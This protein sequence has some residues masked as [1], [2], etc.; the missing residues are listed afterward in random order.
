LS[1]ISAGGF[2]SMSN[3]SVGIVIVSHSDQLALGVR[4][5]ALQMASGADVPVIPAGGTEDGRL[6]TSPDKLL[7][8][9]QQILGQGGSAL[10]LADLGSSIMVAEMVLD[11]L[12][13]EWRERVRLADA[14]LVEGAV[15]A[16]V[17]A[18]GGES[19]DAVQHAAQQVTH[20]SKIL[21]SSSHSAAPPTAPEEI[22]DV[23]EE[24]IELVIKNLSGL[25]AR[26][27]AR[28][29]QAAMQFQSHITVQ[30]ASQQRPPVN[31]KSIVEVASGGTAWRGE[32][33]RIVARGKDAQ[34]AIQTLK[35][36]VESGF[37]E[38]ESPEVAILQ[39]VDSSKEEGLR[40]V[41]ASAG[42][43]IAPVF[44]YR[45]ITC[46]IERYLVQDIAA[47]TAR[48]N[49]ALERA[50][51]ELVNLQQEVAVHH[52]ETAR[53]FEFQRLMLEDPT[54][55]RA[56]ED[57]IQ[58]AALNAEAAASDVFQEW[59]TRFE[60][61]GTEIARQR[62]ADVRDI[63]QRTIRALLGLSEETSLHTV[64]QPV[65]L[66][67]QELTPSDTAR[68][69]RELVTGICTVGGG[70]TSHVA[71][72][73]RMWNIPAV[74]GIEESALNIS[75]GTLVVLDGNTGQLIVNPA[76]EV[77]AT[78]QEK[79]T[80]RTVQIAEAIRQSQEMAITKDGRRIEVF[81][82]IGS[83]AS[84][85]EALSL[86][87]EGVGLLRTEFLFVDRATMPGEEEQYAA[88]R[89]IADVMGDRPL[90][91]RTL[92]IG[93][94]K[95]LPY[96]DL[97]SE[98][99]PF[100]GVRAIRLSLRHLDLF[101]I[102]LRAILRAA[103]GRN[104]KIMF[105]M[106]ATVEEVI[107]AH[108][109]LEEAKAS[110]EKAGIPHATEIET[111]IMIETPAAA[112]VADVLAL[113]VS[114]FSIGSNDLTQYV[115]AC[116]RTNEQLSYLYQQLHPAILRLLRDVIEAA[117]KAKI[118]VGLCGELAGEPKAI[119]LLLGLGLDE[120]SMTPTA[121]PQAKQIIRSLAVDQT[122]KIAQR[123]LTLSTAAEVNQYLE[124]VLRDRG[125]AQDYA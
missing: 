2:A 103:V 14:P 115:L 119:P 93:G 24:S 25:H 86:G 28:F 61:E 59:V 30:N 9:L 44:Q 82:N 120:F 78:Y 118:R 63:E 99:N 5:V 38:S 6:G 45:P 41:P 52:P 40:G 97:P 121:I 33:I 68:L 72:L 49:K 47:E 57:A 77:L 18:A 75:D 26:P 73:A 87:A 96:L 106:V 104:V 29:V 54:L 83:V 81:A 13:P 90:I 4:D 114:F 50:R 69:K 32:R 55:V 70:V 37:G 122:R 64:S 91:I 88:Y 56:I 98:S 58:Q 71:I 12:P 105:P 111:G 16:V 84:A 42:I 95:P 15:A 65:I 10:I 51:Q 20:V 110:L 8:A 43:A 125:F 21:A 117:H 92:D 17:A 35:T 62:S 7:N 102:Q 36:L 113:Q 107:Q 108:R 31:A 60:Q 112:V 76:S 11:N 89:A 74:V 80:R 66:V 109:A 100:L 67:A 34:A 116:D 39:P 123:V 48:L 23:P 101:Q 46:R 3:E 22:A 53:I 85:R 19:L 27:A 94:D 1:Y 124:E 79:Q